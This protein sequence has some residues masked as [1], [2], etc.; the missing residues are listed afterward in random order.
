M[1]RV[2]RQLHLARDKDESDRLQKDQMDQPRFQYPG[3]SELENEQ[4][5]Q[6]NPKAQPSQSPA[7]VGGA[8]NDGLVRSAPEIELNRLPVGNDH[9]RQDPCRANQDDEA[10]QR[11]KVAVPHGHL[12]GQVDEA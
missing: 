9:P 3:P 12:L 2:S 8:M 11:Q 4:A 6:N 7:Q 5:K 1:R 10:S